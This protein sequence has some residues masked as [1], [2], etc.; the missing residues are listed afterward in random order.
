MPHC[1]QD[2]IDKLLAMLDMCRLTLRMVHYISERLVK[3]VPCK[4]ERADGS[5][6]VSVQAAESTCESVH[7]KAAWDRQGKVEL[8]QFFSVQADAVGRSI[9]VLLFFRPI[10]GD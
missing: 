10:F 7:A 2:S 8:V 1:V 6:S 3:A 9:V 4:G 5:T